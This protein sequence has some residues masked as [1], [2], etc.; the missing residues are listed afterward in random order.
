MSS[1]DKSV[2]DKLK[3][4]FRFKGSNITKERDFVLTE[5][6]LRE[7]SRESPTNVRIKTL[8]MLS[9]TV[10]QK[11][12][13]EVSCTRGESCGVS[14]AGISERNRK[15]VDKHAR[16]AVGRPLSGSAAFG[17]VVL[18][19]FAEGTEREVGNVAGA[20]F[21]GDQAT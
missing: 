21:S 19:M 12:L 14:I 18:A 6:I 8:K 5:E 16:S 1:K 11:K 4:L 7:L 2:Q 13:Q 3:Q 17:P 10:L 20:L 9:D 15:T